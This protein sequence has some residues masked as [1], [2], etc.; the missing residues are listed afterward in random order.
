MYINL[1]LT[2]VKWKNNKDLTKEYIF[3]HFKIHMTNG[4]YKDRYII[5]DIDA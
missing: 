1:P 3:V 2:S 4:L 5:C